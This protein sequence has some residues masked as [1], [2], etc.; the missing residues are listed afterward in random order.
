[1]R[2]PLQPKHTTEVQYKTI[3]PHWDQSFTFGLP[4]N[5][6]EETVFIAVWGKH[7][8]KSNTLIGRVEVPVTLVLQPDFADTP[9][10]YKEDYR[11]E[12]WFRLLPREGDKNVDQSFG[13]VKLAFT[14]KYIPFVTEAVKQ[15]SD[16][17]TLP[18]AATPV[19]E[20]GSD[21]N[22]MIQCPTCSC[23]FDAQSMQY[24]VS[25]CSLLTSEAINQAKRETSNPTLV[26]RS[27]Q[28]FSSPAPS[29]QRD[30]SVPA[31]FSVDPSQPSANS[32]PTYHSPL[33][34]FSRSPPASPPA[35]SFLSTSPIS[36]SPARVASS[37]EDLYSAPTY[38]FSFPGQ[39]N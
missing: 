16:A 10:S 32:P 36:S 12:R 14:Y 22:P 17:Y 5:P 8:I 7:I 1:M 39:E 11:V 19:R 6:E 23:L 24:H 25:H 28:V 20:C 31:G 13:W 34:Q 27:P 2:E 29:P 3:T 37:T 30:I 4:K 18:Q 26:N 15:V 38:S 9:S 21:S 33:S 35:G